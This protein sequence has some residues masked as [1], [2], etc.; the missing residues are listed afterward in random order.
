MF[1]PLLC[2]CVIILQSAWSHGLSPVI[3]ATIAFGMGINKASGVNTFFCV[4]RSVVLIMLSGIDTTV[5]PF[6]ICQNPTHFCP[7]ISRCFNFCAQANVRWIVHFSL[8]KS[9]EGYYQESGEISVCVSFFARIAAASALLLLASYFL[10]C[11]TPSPFYPSPLF[12]ARPR[13]RRPRRHG[14]QVHRAL[15]LWRLHEEHQPDR[16]VRRGG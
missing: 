5:S 15:P 9:L 12:S 1:R 2:L 4:C 6:G 3:C 11:L 14:R 13:P 16:Q 8:P 10:V 7:V